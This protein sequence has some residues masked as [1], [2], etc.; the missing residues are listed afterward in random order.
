MLPAGLPARQ[1]IPGRSARGTAGELCPKTAPA[2][3]SPRS[4][5]APPQQLQTLR[6]QRHFAGRS[7]TPR[8][9]PNKRDPKRSIGPSPPNYCYV[10]PSLSFVINAGTDQMGAVITRPSHG[11]AD[12][13]KRNRETPL[14]FPPVLKAYAM[15]DFDFIRRLGANDRPSCPKTVSFPSAHLLPPAP[16]FLTLSRGRD[17]QLARRTAAPA[18]PA[19]GGAH[20][21]QTP[22]SQPNCG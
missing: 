4:G 20:R 12:C 9:G 6:W 18:P 16:V 14:P 5:V 1:L 15:Y 21:I 3:L 7:D 10:A 22:A 19:P 11:V 17:P 13:R 8:S 2:T